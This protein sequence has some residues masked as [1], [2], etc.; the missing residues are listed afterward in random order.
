MGG[1]LVFFYQ[2]KVVFRLLYT[3]FFIIKKST[4]VLIFHLLKIFDYFGF[5]VHFDLNSS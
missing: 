3:F 2:F 1:A 5:F 4:F